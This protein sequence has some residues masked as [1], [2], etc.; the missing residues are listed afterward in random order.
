MQKL[1]FLQNFVC[2]YALYVFV[3]HPFTIAM[4]EDLSHL[5]PEERLEE[6][7][8]RADACFEAQEFHKAV[9][10]AEELLQLEEYLEPDERSF[11]HNRL[12]VLYINIGRP[13]DALIHLNET[14]RISRDITKDISAYSTALNNISMIYSDWGEHEKALHYLDQSLKI[15]IEQGDKK[16]EATALNNMSSI[17]LELKDYDGAL[18]RL[19]RCLQ[20]LQEIEDRT[21]EAACLGNIGNIFLHKGDYKQALQYIRQAR[22]LHEETGNRV[23]LASTLHVL[24]TLSLALGG[25]T[26]SY[27][28]Y[29]REAWRIANE[30]GSAEAIFE[31][32]RVLGLALCT[33]GNRREGLEILNKVLKIGRQM[34]TPD[35]KDVADTIRQ[36]S[37]G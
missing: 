18:Q 23:G 19:Q 36:F 14:L 8:Q 2:R 21:N 10:Y 31:I 20:V 27:F 6:L 22:A 16:G 15:C 17:Y 30:V 4:S 11:W 7:A 34:G 1:I 32:G 12:G 33:R 24:A 5:D 37:G 26:V 3:V 25:D 28:R 13:E 29:E 35:A 9:E